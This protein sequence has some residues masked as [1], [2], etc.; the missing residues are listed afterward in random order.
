[1]GKI[2]SYF[3]MGM[4]KKRMKKKTVLLMRHINNDKKK[5]KCSEHYAS[6]NTSPKLAIEMKNYFP[7]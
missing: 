7:S 3:N 4:D 5:A 2:F 1:M 6:S